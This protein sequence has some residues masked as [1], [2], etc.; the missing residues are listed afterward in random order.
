MSRRYYKREY[1]PVP[2]EDLE[3]LHHSDKFDVL[4]SI[5]Y[6]SYIACMQV[7]NDQR[8]LVGSEPIYEPLFDI[9]EREYIKKKIFEL[10][11]TL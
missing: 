7:V 3:A 1:V 9:H 5:D 6:L 2:V 4:Q 11:N 10:I 8:T